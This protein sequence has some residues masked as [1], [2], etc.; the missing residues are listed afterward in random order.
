MALIKI[1]L[2]AL[3]AHAAATYAIA[4]PIVAL[5]QQTKSESSLIQLIKLKLKKDITAMLTAILRVFSGIINLQFS[6][7][8]F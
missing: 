2:I 6:I 4:A 3:T 5:F 7:Y 1:A 8:N